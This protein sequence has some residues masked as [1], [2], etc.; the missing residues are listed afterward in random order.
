MHS[1]NTPIT[2]TRPR[3]KTGAVLAWIALLLGFACVA[4]VLLAALGY[5]TEGLSLGTAIQSIRWA[6]T[7]ALAGAVGA[8]LSLVWILRAGGAR[9]TA[10]LVAAAAL[11]LNGLVAAPPLYLFAQAKN[12]P[13]IH[14]IS[15]DTHEPPRFVAIVPLRS[16]APNPVE[17]DLANAAEQQRG[18]PDIA[19]MVLPDTSPAQS[20]ARAERAARALGWDI[21]STVPVEGRLEATDSTP[22]LG[23]KDDIVVRIREIA[24]ESGK[25]SGSVVDVRSVSRVGL[26]DIG[27]NARRIRAF[28][29]ELQAQ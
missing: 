4:A 11:V 16:S 29:R 21:V 15:T 2:Q 25:G 23:F 17:Y 8:L 28:L 6:A 14:D 24:A 26:S 13:R 20:F 22:L 9:R 10:L 5:R 3:T 18:Y 7:G 27:T 1:L 12:L 19:P